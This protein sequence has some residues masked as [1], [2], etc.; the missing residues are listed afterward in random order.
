M[1][2]LKMSALPSAVRPATKAIRPAGPAAG[3]GI[4]DDMSAGSSPK[5]NASKKRMGI[6]SSTW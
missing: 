1:S 5:Y 2:A 3:W 6:L 4:G